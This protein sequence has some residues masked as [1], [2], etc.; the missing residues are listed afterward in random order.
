VASLSEL[1]RLARHRGFQPPPSWDPADRDA[2]LDWLMATQVAPTLGSEQPEI[3]YHYPASQA[4][5]AQVRGDTTP[6]ALR[7]ELYVHGVELAN[8]YQELLDPQVLEKRMAD[9]NAQRLADGKY[10]LP[11]HNQLLLAMEHGLPSCT[12]VALGFDRLVMVALGASSLAQVMA[13][14]IDRA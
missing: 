14:P 4:G 1:E 8:G 9:G 10:S 11:T 13:F 2:W 3:L 5:L 12:G 7:F 6:V